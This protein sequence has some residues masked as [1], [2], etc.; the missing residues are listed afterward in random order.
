MSQTIFHFDRATRIYLGAGE[1]RPN[2]EEPGAFLIPGFATDVAPPEAGPGQVARFDLNAGAWELMDAPAPGGEIVPQ[3]EL[4][5]EQRMQLL[6]QGV[7]EHLDAQAREMGY[8]NVFTAVTYADEPAVP[9]FQAEGQALRAW[10]SLVWAKCYELLGDFVVAT[11]AGQE[12]AE[13][14][15]AGVVAQ[16]PAFQAPEVS[17]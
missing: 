17:A 4:T 10:R 11:A 8:D 1:A 5:F 9:K 12:V 13:P 16:L 15:L 7:Q 2:P 6:Q 3:P 14:T